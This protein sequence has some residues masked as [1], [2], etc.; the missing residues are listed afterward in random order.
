M[1]EYLNSRRCLYTHADKIRSMSDEELAELLIGESCKVCN[2][3]RYPN[4][5]ECR[6]DWLKEVKE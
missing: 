2:S 1:S 6:L 4:C 5:K 3:D